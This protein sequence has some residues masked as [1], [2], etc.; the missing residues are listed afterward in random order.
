MNNKFTLVDTDM[1][2]SSSYNGLFMFNFFLFFLMN[3]KAK[4]FFFFV[5]IIFINNLIHS[6][7]LVQTGD[8]RKNRESFKNPRKKQKTEIKQT[9][10]ASTE[11]STSDG[12]KEEKSVTEEKPADTPATPAVEKK[13]E[14][15]N[16]TVPKKEE[17]NEPVTCE[18]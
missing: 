3:A 18:S 16:G 2:P 1:D 11:S 10:T 12:I 14:K 6:L 13:E 9:P 15:E 7:Q 4:V 5:S 17:S 8:G